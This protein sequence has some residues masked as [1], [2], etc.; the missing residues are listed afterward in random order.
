[1][2]GRRLG[3]APLT[4]KFND[5]IV[6]RHII[7]INIDC[8]GFKAGST[9]WC[10][11]GGVIVTLPLGVFPLYSVDAVFLESVL[12]HAVHPLGFRFRVEA[13]EA[14]LGCAAGSAAVVLEIVETVGVEGALGGRGEVGGISLALDAFF[15]KVD[16]ATSDGDD[17]ED[18]GE[19]G[20]P[21]EQ[22][23][24]DRGIGP[25]VISQQTSG[26]N[27]IV[28]IMGIFIYVKSCSGEVFSHKGI[29]IGFIYKKACELPNVNAYIGQIIEIR[30]NP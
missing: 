17:D 26:C 25:D 22:D 30:K 1:M 19:D 3:P 7:V 15:L 28:I 24:E 8:D 5:L 13:F 21:D 2:Q 16:A 23:Q 27:E 6:I 20:K 18:E 11:C 29:V 14:F 10:R 9:L 4:A 12:S